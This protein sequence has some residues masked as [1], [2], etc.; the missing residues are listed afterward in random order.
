M[1]WCDHCHQAEPQL[2]DHADS[3]GHLEYLCGDCW[4]HATHHDNLPASRLKPETET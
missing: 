3:N 4:L 1:T 2:S